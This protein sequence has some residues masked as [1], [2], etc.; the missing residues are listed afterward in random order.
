[1]YGCTLWGHM[2]WKLSKHVFNDPSLFPV[3]VVVIAHVS[4]EAFVTCL[5]H[6][7]KYM[8]VRVYTQS[9]FEFLEGRCDLTV[10]RIL[11]A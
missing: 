3:L 1:M 5:A 4:H 8:Y 2:R 11:S 7:Y 10:L 6:V 9:Y